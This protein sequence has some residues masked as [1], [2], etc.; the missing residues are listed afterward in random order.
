MPRARFSTNYDNSWDDN[1]WDD[2]SSWDSPIEPPSS[3]RRWLVLLVLIV[4]LFAAGAFFLLRQTGTPDAAAEAWLQALVTA[5]IQKLDEL[6]CANPPSAEQSGIPSGSLLDAVTETIG[7][8]LDLLGTR[9]D[10]STL[11]EYLEFD[12]AQI[13]YETIDRQDGAATVSVHGPLSIHFTLISYPLE[14]HEQWQ[15]SREDGSW[16]W[17][18]R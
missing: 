14:L 15:M 8:D 13:E 5:D 17:C 11:S 7:L 6:T 10:L 1:G 2:S 9:V 4:V 3:K 16:K 18:G 12:T